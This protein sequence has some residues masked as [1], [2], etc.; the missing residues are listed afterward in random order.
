VDPGFTFDYEGKYL[1]KGT[2]A[3]CPANTTDELPDEAQQAAG[4][5]P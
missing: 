4:V 1:G 3:I 2:R 5:A